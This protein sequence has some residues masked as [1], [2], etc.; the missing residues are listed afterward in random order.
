M[1]ANGGLKRDV[2]GNWLEDDS[3]TNCGRVVAGDVEGAL[4]TEE[5]QGA[6]YDLVNFLTY[7]GEPAALKR[8]RLGVYVLMFIGVFFIFAYLLNREYWKDVDH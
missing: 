6:M 4:T 8:E 5:F 2:D 3:E 7:M 1:A